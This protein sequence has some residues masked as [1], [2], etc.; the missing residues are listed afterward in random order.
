MFYKKSN[1]HFLVIKLICDFYYLYITVNTISIEYI[2]SNLNSINKPFMNKH[3]LLNS[4]IKDLQI[5]KRLSTKIPVDQVNFRPKENVRSTLEILQ[6]LCNCGTNTI[7]YWYR[8]DGSDL[9]TFS[10][11]RNAYLKTLTLDKIAAELDAQIE[12]A[13]HLFANITESDLVNKEVDF[14]WGEKAMLGEA[15]MNT[16]IKWLAA[17]KLQLFLNIKLSTDEK[18]TTPDLWRKTELD[19]LVKSN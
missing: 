5:V 13:K 1:V 6:Y 8:T 4:I 11:E 14:P 15:I 2:C 19:D 17:Y 10:A 18:I 16:N 12:M 3:I 7:R 9:K